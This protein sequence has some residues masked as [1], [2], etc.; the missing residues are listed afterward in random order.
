MSVRDALPSILRGDEAADL[1]PVD[2]ERLE[3]LAR[4]APRRRP[5]RR[6]C[7]TSAPRACKQPGAEPGV[8]YLLAVACA[9][10]GEIERA[11]Q[12]LL[13]AGREARGREAAGSRSPRSPS[14]RSTL[15]ETQAAA[16]LLVRRT[17]A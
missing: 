11:H 4:D 8:E 5:A 1:A 7:A 16:R 12:T 6:S 15:E 9:L 14:A 10:N 3:A 13:D 2:R 17:R